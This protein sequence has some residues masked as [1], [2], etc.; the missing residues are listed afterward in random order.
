MVYQELVNLGSDSGVG[1]ALISARD[2]AIKAI[3]DTMATLA[4]VVFITA[5]GPL[6][7]LY[8]AY[9]L[10]SDPTRAGELADRN[11]VFDPLFLSSSFEALSQ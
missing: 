11:A 4:Q 6:P 3:S 10:Y 2:T 8:W 7:A 1:A 9:R 5:P